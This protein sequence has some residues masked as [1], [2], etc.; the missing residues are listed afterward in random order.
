M[1]QGTLGRI[2]GIVALAL[3]V[4]AS[5]QIA[6]SEVS[7]P[8]TTAFI[9]KPNVQMY[10]GFQ[11]WMA[12][13]IAVADFNR[14][15]WPDIFWASGAGTASV[16][17][18][19]R[20]F[21]NNGDGTFTN[22]AAQWGL[23]LVHAVMGA[24]AGDFDDDGW[25]DL[26]LTSFGN[27]T[28]N[29]GQLGKNVLWRNNGNGSFTNVAAAAGVAANTVFTPNGYGCVFGDYDLDGDLDLA[30]AAW[31]DSA[32]GNRLY[33]NNGDGT[34]TDVTGVAV[35]FPASLHGFT[36]NFADMDG[37]GW[38][39]LLLAADFGTSCYFRNNGNGTF[40]NITA[41][42]GTG[43]DEFGMGQCIGDFDNDGRFDWYVTSII[44]DTPELGSGSGNKLYRNLGNHLYAE[45]GVA[46]GVVDGGWGWGASAVDFDN[47]GWLDI[48][49][50]NGRP[51]SPTYSNLPEFLYRNDGDGTFSNVTAQAG[52][53]FAAE[54]KAVSSLDYDRDGRVDLAITFNGAT[55]GAVSN[56]APNKLYRNTSNAQSWLGLTFDTQSNPRIAPMGFGTRVT[57][58]VGSQSW[59]RFVDSAPNFLGTGEIGAHFGL[60][61]ATLVDEVTIEW[62]RG[63]TTTLTGV[64]ANQYLVVVAPELCDF[65]SNGSVDGA[66][67]GHLL[68]V[69]GPLGL[70]SDRRADVN[71]DGTVNGQD[72]EA[73]LAAW[74]P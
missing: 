65:D 69:W 67:L 54:G 26:F 68:S 56:G 23:G 20:L 7:V 48:V 41:A 66:D 24:C 51:G 32:D 34:F 22:R 30:V 61:R 43:L 58:R 39:E 16:P 57:A 33:R 47:D 36:P 60:G 25:P 2:A 35:T 27:G 5:A 45:I 71:N 44:S 59:I 10:P 15:G 70:T 28:N 3:S 14:D 50:V 8:S 19:D 62:P 74:N 6:L 52:L 40:T 37:D 18:P 31:V 1:S 11:D 63:Y 13:G 29:Q 64:R 73:M 53:T 9:H 12:G 46:A 17:T 21:I 72:L 55:N 49:E 42:S 38:P 4:K